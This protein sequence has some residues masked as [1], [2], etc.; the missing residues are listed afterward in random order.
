[1]PRPIDK[2]LLKMARLL[3]IPVSAAHLTVVRGKDSKI[4]LSGKCAQKAGFL[5]GSD[6]A[7]IGSGTS[8]LY[9]LV[10]APIQGRPVAC[11]LVKDKRFNGWH[12]CSRTS[13]RLLQ[14]AGNQYEEDEYPRFRFVGEPHHL[15]TEVVVWRIDPHP[16][17]DIRGL[18]S[19]YASKEG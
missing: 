17:K 11:K 5:P 10:V 16:I 9:L 18:S 12:F 7:V 4:Y 6:V 3:R 1:M 14:W 15:T 2:D 13:R 8:R 19:K